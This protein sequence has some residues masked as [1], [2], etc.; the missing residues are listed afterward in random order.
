MGKFKRVLGIAALIAGILIGGAIGVAKLRGSAVRAAAGD[1][2][3]TLEIGGLARMYIVHVPP[4]YDGKTALPLVLVL[5]G[6]TQSPESVERMSA[7]SE[8]ADAENFLV[9]YPRGTGRIENIPTWNSGACCGYAMENHVD[10]VAFLSALI[11][12]LEQEYKVDS[13]RIYSTGISNGA[14]MSFRLACDLADKIAAVA[15][16]EG[17]QDIPCHPAVPVSVIVFHGTA[18]RLVPFEGGS[19]PFQVGSRRSDTPVPDTI[20]YWVKEDGCSP[21]S[22]HAETAE[23]HTDKYSRCK[24]GTAVELYAIQGGHH[25]WPGTRMSGNT[26]PATDLI[27]KFF[28]EHPKP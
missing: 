14:M 13:K 11:D 7:M 24:D 25:I 26:V 6:A 23:L 28:A 16:V 9:V 27:W 12:R 10:D 5:H 22:N 17:A 20:A 21:E 19:T 18:D 2:T 3:G 8:K 15:P 4:G 1:K